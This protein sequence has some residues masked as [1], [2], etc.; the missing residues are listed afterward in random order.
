MDLR[1]AGGQR[2]WGRGLPR[3]QGGGAAGVVATG[4]SQVLGA[5]A[6]AKET[7]R[8]GDRGAKGQIVMWVQGG[9]NRLSHSTQ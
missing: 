7:H 8:A 5:L 2:A 3:R 9:E 4:M 6:G 1:P